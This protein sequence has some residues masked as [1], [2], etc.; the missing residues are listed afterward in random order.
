MVHILRYDNFLPKKASK[1]YESEMTN[2]GVKN[3]EQLYILF[4]ENVFLKVK[5][6]NPANIYLFK[7]NNKTKPKKKV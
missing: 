6:D 5:H 2:N 7:V 1:R 4:G 3:V